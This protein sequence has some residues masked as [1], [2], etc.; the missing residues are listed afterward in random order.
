MPKIIFVSDNA[1]LN[2][3]FGGSSAH[4]DDLVR[5]FHE[6][7]EIERTVVERAGQPEA[8]VYEH[9]FARPISLIH[10]AD[11]RDGG[12]RF[13]DH[14][15]KIS[16]KKID[17]RIRLGAGR[18]TGQMSGIIF[19]PIAEA[20]LLQHLQI[21]FGAHAQPLCFEKFVLPFKIDDSLFQF[22]ADGSQG[23]I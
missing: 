10:T 14:D 4:V 22:F 21:V 7:I 18:T 3:E 9:G 15:Q 6:L 13:I 2:F 1:V 16:R 23:A 5:H 11:L 19:D 8:V 20:H 17:N 12:V